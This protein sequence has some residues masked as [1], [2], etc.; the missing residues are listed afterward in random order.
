MARSVASRQSRR[1]REAR[2]RPGCEHD[3]RHDPRTSVA[4]VELIE[5][6][7]A[8]ATDPIMREPQREYMPRQPSLPAPHSRP[9]ET[10]M[11]TPP[12]HTN[13]RTRHHPHRPR[14]PT[15]P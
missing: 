2:T 9:T 5:P 11:G 7:L 15:H 12:R 1:P 10:L 6:T 3:D 4:V 8:V 14:A 13:N